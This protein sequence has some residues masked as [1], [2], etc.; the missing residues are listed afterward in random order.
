[1]NTALER[2]LGL[3]GKKSGVPATESKLP[4]GAVRQSSVHIDTYALR[5][6][7]GSWHLEM[8]GEFVG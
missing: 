2:N 8:W 3:M 4:F 1:M 7:S 6:C 5:G